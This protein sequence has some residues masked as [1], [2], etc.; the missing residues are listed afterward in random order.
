[1][2]TH[3]SVEA[4]SLYLGFK[5]STDKT[6][7]QSI[8]ISD[9]GEGII[10]TELTHGDEMG[11]LVRNSPLLDWVLTYAQS[12]PN[13]FPH[14]SRWVTHFQRYRFGGDV[15]AFDLIMKHSEVLFPIR[16]NPLA[17][18]LVNAL[19]KAVAE[20]PRDQPSLWEADPR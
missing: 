18:L 5:C 2:L 17:Q 15:K 12:H 8:K 9:W 13:I 11:Y 7:R 6:K 3:G 20:T 19:G 14:P 1:M 4:L 10:G 16:A